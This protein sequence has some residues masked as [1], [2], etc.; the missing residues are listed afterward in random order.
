[1]RRYAVI[2]ADFLFQFRINDSPE[3]IHWLAQEYQ[4]RVKKE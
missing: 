4:S 1:M 3:A 2:T